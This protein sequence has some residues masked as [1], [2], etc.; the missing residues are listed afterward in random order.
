M[1]K[2]LYTAVTI[3][4]F[5]A[6]DTPNKV[7][8]NPDSTTNTTGTTGSANMTNATAPASQHTPGTPSDSSVTKK[9]SLPR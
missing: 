1:K 3:F 6:C 9:D 7:I 5:A 8:G 2:I 4:I